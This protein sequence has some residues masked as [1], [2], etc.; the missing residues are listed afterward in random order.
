[1]NVSSIKMII[2]LLK[3]A[4]NFVVSCIFVFLM[5]VGCICLAMMYG[6]AEMIPE[7]FSPVEYGVTMQFILYSSGMLAVLMAGLI[8]L[9]KTNIKIEN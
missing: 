5:S 7:A 1:M 9:F 6:A 8:L 2:G 4:V 3:K